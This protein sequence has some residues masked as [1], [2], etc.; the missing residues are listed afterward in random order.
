MVAYAVLERSPGVGP[1]VNQPV[2]GQ[3]TGRVQ[4][5]HMMGTDELAGAPGTEEVGRVGQEVGLWGCGAGRHWELRA[6]SVLLRG[7]AA[8]LAQLWARWG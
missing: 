7:C 2:S 1:H 8:N 4:G 3:V 5:E 6:L